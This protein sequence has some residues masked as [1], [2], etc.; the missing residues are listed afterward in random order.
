MRAWLTVQMHHHRSE[1]WVVVKGTASVTRGEEVR[2]LTENESVYIPVGT[3]HRLENPGTIDLELIEV[4]SGAYLGE[5]GIV[6]FEDRYHRHETP[7]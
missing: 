7:T 1:H 3:I 4:Q 5:D 2:L 6:R